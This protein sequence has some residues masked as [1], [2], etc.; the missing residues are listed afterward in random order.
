VMVDMVLQSHV[1]LKFYP[2]SSLNTRQAA[3]A[4]KGRR[5]SIWGASSKVSAGGAQA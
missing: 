2:T 5:T 3:M 1:I 4:R